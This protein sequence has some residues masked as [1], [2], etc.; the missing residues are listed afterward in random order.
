MK[1]FSKAFILSVLTA[2]LAL[3]QPSP[4]ATASPA[5]ARATARKAPDPASAPA[6]RLP[7]GKP[8]FSGIWLSPGPIDDLA[9]G[10]PK[11][12][13]IP[14]KCLRHRQRHHQEAR[15]R[16][17]DESA[18]QRLRGANIVGQPGI[19]AVHPPD[20]RQNQKRAGHLLQVVGVQNQIADLGDGKDKH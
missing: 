11:G 6:P 20:D 3:G 10:L 14:P 15:H 19:A 13:T 18:V 17:Q 5:G 9:E 1:P 16:R 4:A 12:E 8:D 7:D 2:T